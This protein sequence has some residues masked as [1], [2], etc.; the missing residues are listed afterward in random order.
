MNCVKKPILTTLTFDLSHDCVSMMP[1]DGG[2]DVPSK[3]VKSRVS[4][5]P[6]S[7]VIS[8][9][10]YPTS[11]RSRPSPAALGTRFLTRYVADSARREPVDWS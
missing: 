8:F 10:S 5:Q 3:N 11:M 4:V 6:G 9:D 2:V 1:S 7:P